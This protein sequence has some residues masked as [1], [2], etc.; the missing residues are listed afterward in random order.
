LSTDNLAN[1]DRLK[2][3]EKYKREEE[4]WKSH[5]KPETPKGKW[6]N[7]W[8]H[9]KWHTI[10]IV[11]GVAFVA[12]FVYSMV[13]REKYDYRLMFISSKPVTEQTTKIIETE[14][15]KYAK[16]LNGDKKSNV[17]VMPIELNSEENNIN[18]QIL[19]ANTT[20]YMAELS[21]GEI[22]VFIVDKVNYDAN[23]ENEILCDRNGE[24]ATK[25]T[26]IEQVAYPVKDT[27]IGKTLKENGLED[28]YYICFRVF[29]GT[30]DD[31]NDKKAENNKQSHELINRYLEAN[32]QVQE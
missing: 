28:D 14:L 26:P 24:K 23:I 21:T 6:E 1:L 4:I 8:Y 30:K 16:D 3:P 22:M 18:P 13:T 20:K 32:L 10:G 12:F 17:S 9:Y 31:K 25:D 2:N 11:L 29:N 19:Q 5:Q 7:Y 27:E 15:A